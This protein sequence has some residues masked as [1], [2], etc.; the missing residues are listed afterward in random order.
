MRIQLAAAVALAPLMMASGAA[1]QTVISNERTTPISTSTAN[2]GAPD[3]IRIANTGL[4]RLSSGAAVTV[5]S[6]HNLTLDL[7]SRIVM[8]SAADG[9]TAILVH[10]GNTASIE[11]RSVITIFDSVTA[12]DSDND[13]DA[14]GAFASGTGRYGI[15]VVGPGALTGDVH[16]NGTI[17]VEGN[18]SAAISIE[19]DLIG[20]LIQSGS[21]TMVGD[22]S[23][24]LRTTGSVSGIY[25]AGGQIAVTGAG[26]VGV[27]V[28]GDL[29]GRLTFGGGITATGFRYTGQLS[30]TQIE[31]LDADD[32][33]IGGPAVS[34]SANVGAGILFD[35]PHLND[36]SDTDDDDDGI[37]DVD[38]P[39][40]NNNGV[41]DTEESASSIT[42]F[43]SAPAV[44]IGS[45]TQTVTV[46]VVGTGDQA[47]GIINRGSIVGN[48]IYEGIDAT[49]LRIGVDGGMAVT[50][51]GGFR[52][53]GTLLAISAN[54]TATALIVDANASLPVVDN[55][56]II[57]SLM[58]GDGAFEAVGVDYRAGAIA[59]SLINSGTIGAYV[60]GEAS[61]A[62]AIRDTSGTLTSL[63]NR[64]VIEALVSPTDDEDDTDDDNLNAGDEVITGRAVAI[65]L[66]AN[67]SGVTLVQEGINDGDDY[68]DGLA[69]ADAD[70]DGVDDDDEPAIVGEI[71]LGSGNDTVEINNG[72]VFGDISF[73]D[74][75]DTFLIDG[76]AVVRGALSDSD[77]QL[78]VDV[79]DGV[80][81]ARQT[82][83]L[84][85]SGLNV[86]TNGN[87]VVTIDP[88]NNTVG[89]FNVNGTA[90]FASGAGVGIRFTSLLDDPTRF[91]VVQATT[92][93]A[94]D[95][96]QSQVQSNSPYMYVVNAGI[97]NTLN[98]IYVDARQRTAAE[99]G[100]ITAETDTYGAFY[101]ALATDSELLNAFLAQTGRDGFFEMYQQVLP[102]H[103]GGSL[104]SLATGVDA[105]TRALS[106]RGHPAPLGETSAWLQEINFYADRDKGNAYGFRSEGFGFAGGVE[107]GTGFGALGVSFALTSSDLED[108]ESRAEESLSAQLLEL[109]MYWRA[110]GVSW[111]VWARGAA[112]FASFDS[113]RQLVAPGINRRNESDWN[114]YSLALAAGA[115]Y[116]YRTGR[117]SIRPEAFVEYFRLSEDAH[118]ES[119]GGDGFDLAYEDREGHI[120]SST[121]A[122]TVGAGFGENQ[123]LRPEVRVGWRQVF[124]HD[125]G[126]TVASFLSTGTPFALQGDSLEGG[127]PIV[128]LRLNLG[129]ELGFLALEAD[130]EMLDD[131]VRYALLLRASFK[132]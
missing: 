85:V 10:G 67:T 102:D 126:T 63:T 38:D 97:D 48:G 71:L 84:T 70:G 101:E 43:G 74:G 19:T 129:N 5:D 13:G 79:V 30:Q 94:T 68:A 105:V 124:S 36:T 106:G 127:G 125:P 51:D 58:T 23:Y 104:I 118:E 50:I 35:L 91:V 49:A 98:Q 75:A 6:S 64:G 61:D 73:G 100:F 128:G 93:N 119:G 83:S 9:A 81:D 112:G 65:D 132:F 2:N 87:L 57:R 77:G 111:N 123:W 72:S 44:Q 22:Q 116:D 32:L 103:S 27:S 42:S 14:D 90:N 8:E 54:G 45:T 96:D 117:W 88:L 108:P 53:S 107:H 15:R 80:L 56:A 31:R 41:V 60:Q 25:F 113:V 12:T 130:A 46:G 16:N 109:G 55:T 39:D 122:V 120:L 76:G 131:Y 92:L 78:M 29:A 4:I 59:G 86:G 82:S 115:A 1:A 99:F 114:G 17:T 24:G 20:N 66:S 37:L 62:Y 26:S 52:N 7:G 110:Q 89:G 11:N 18:Q 95:L 34:V 69:D 28:E 47:F 33:L 21:I 40:D 3:S 121:I